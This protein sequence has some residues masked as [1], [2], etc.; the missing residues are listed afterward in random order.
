MTFSQPEGFCSASHRSRA[1]WRFSHSSG[2]VVKA[3]DS[4]RA[5]SGLTPARSLTILESVLR[6]T[7][8]VWARADTDRPR[9]GQ[10]VTLDD[11][12]GMRRLA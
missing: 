12:A 2:V 6:E 10:I 1:F 8:R 9:G 5:M 11:P 3:R 4:R 7:P